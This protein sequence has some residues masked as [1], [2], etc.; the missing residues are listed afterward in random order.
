MSGTSLDGI[1]LAYVEF[2]ENQGEWNYQLIAHDSKAYSLHWKNKLSSLP[3]GSALELAKTHNDYG[4]YTGTII[5]DFLIKHQVKPD[6]I[7]VHGH[8]I[9]HQ[10][11]I[12]LTTQI[13]NGAF[14]ATATKS[15][16]ACDFRSMDVALQG[17]G[18][19]LVPIGDKLLYGTYPIRIN[20][21]GFANISYQDQNKTVAYDICPVNIV[22]NF[23]AQKMGKQFDKD[24]EIA[25]NGQINHA[26]L[27]QL[28]KLKHYKTPSP[29]SLG[30]E[31]VEQHIFP[32]LKKE[33]ATSDLISTISEHSAQ[34]IA[35]SINNT[36]LKQGSKVLLTG[37]GAFNK[38]LIERIQHYSS[39]SI[40]LPSSE[41]ID[42]KEAI[43]FAFLGVL[44]LRN[45]HNTI[46]HATGALED[47]IS[48]ALY[49]GRKSNK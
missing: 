2:N 40:L 45:N 7:G 43:I 37:G 39:L 46:R 11:Q 12:S 4:K 30:K 44:R 49:E 31:W 41:E 35:F 1:D 29:K 25:R 23:L 14:I 32:L 22:L 21:G 10:P 33:I 17:Q 34:Q 27:T 6:I 13:G 26:L 18:A 5:N 47:C 19:P 42:M 24:G 3:Q 38:H 36:N 16:V 15:L 48:G 8:T 28:N 20:L 9:F